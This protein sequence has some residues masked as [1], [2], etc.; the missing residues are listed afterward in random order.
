M[1]RASLVRTDPHTRALMMRQAQRGGGNAMLARWVDG[2]PAD[3][4]LAD[5]MKDLGNLDDAGRIARIQK[6]VGGGDPR[7]IEILWGGF[8]DQEKAAK[9]NPDLFAKSVERAPGLASRG[10]FKELQEKFK[11]DVEA[12]ALGH[13]SA[14][15][16]Y[17]T[18][19]MEKLGVSG[20]DKPQTAEQQHA[21][22]DVQKAA[23]LIA[24][25][26]EAIERFTKIPV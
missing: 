1:S 17:V 19:E 22:H 13:L 9:A 14:N 4:K 12:V 11:S 6:E 18:A 20:E 15:R 3:Q 8:G 2:D 24:K 7:L 25:C 26:D 10:P 5:D 21:L 16:N 23:A